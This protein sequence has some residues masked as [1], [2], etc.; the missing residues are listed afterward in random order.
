M[1]LVVS[2]PV[3]MEKL[4]ASLTEKFPNYTVKYALWNKKSIRVIDGMNQ[5]VVGQRKNGK[6]I[7]VGNINMLDWRFFVPFV[8]LMAAMIITGI[9][10]L[11]I[12]S[13]IKKK[14]FK[15]L[16]GEVQNYLQEYIKP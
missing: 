3:D 11:V 16:E 9:L 2:Q 5:V 13:V 8:L 15:A 10:F 12:M 14:Q 4:K 6:M 1:E 7:C